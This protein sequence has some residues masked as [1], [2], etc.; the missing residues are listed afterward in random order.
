MTDPDN[1]PRNPERGSPL[2]LEERSGMLILGSSAPPTDEG[3]ITL[4][5]SVRYTGAFTTDAGKEQADQTVDFY[6]DYE[7]ERIHSRVDFKT[8]DDS[9]EVSPLGTDIRFD[10]G[11]IDVIFDNTTL[12][13]FE[14][15][16]V[17]TSHDP[18]SLVGDVGIYRYNAAFGRR[19]TAITSREDAKIG[20]NAMYADRPG[21]GVSAPVRIQADDLSDF[22]AS[23]EPGTTV[24]RYDPSLGGQ[25][26]WALDISA[27]LGSVR[28]GYGHRRDRGFHPGVLAD[29]TRGS[30][31]FTVTTHGTR[32]YWNGQVV[33]LAVG[34]TRHVTIRGGL[35]WGNTSLR[36]LATTTATVT[37]IGDIALGPN[38]MGAD[39]KQDLQT[40]SRWQGGIRY[41]NEGW[42]IDAQY[43]WNDFEF[44][45]G[46]FPAADARIGVADISLSYGSDRW[47]I[48]SRFAYSDH[49]YRASPVQFHFDTSSRNRWLDFGDRLTIG[50][51]ATFDRVEVGEVNVSGEWS[52]ADSTTVPG[53]LLLRASFDLMTNEFLEST[54]YYALRGAAEYGLP[55]GFFVQAD[56]RLAR[57]EK[58]EWMLNDTFLSSYFEI[59][60]RHR[61]GEISVGVGLDPIVLDPATSQYSDIGREE[62]VRRAIPLGLQR[63][64]SAALGAA[65]AAQ[66]AALEDEYPIKLEAIIFF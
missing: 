24:Y 9:W 30:G 34:A 4:Q 6:F 14:N 5:P 20:F 53:Y 45:G 40:S 41:T 10:R 23:T 11:Y 25:D 61:Y 50:H 28:F 47:Q 51:I 49:D 2:A 19:G 57:Y 66:E 7:T 54:D 64:Q 43:Q 44:G 27:N 3:R 36:R 35:G 55:W 17:W 12:R 15:E 33:W 63:D 52:N 37:T 39:A 32:E 62:F 31:D 21:T 60:Y 46:P 65:V 42:R 18:F 1:P 26:T 58:S 8:S 16:H 56:A 48:E 38:A 59:G 22:V 13:A 29:I